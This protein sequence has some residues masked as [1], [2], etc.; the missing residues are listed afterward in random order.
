MA[1]TESLG[2]PDKVTVSGVWLRKTGGCVIVA[3]EIEGKWIDVIT[4]RA[5]S[6][7]SHIVE[8]GGI[9]EG[10]RILNRQETP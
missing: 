5:D 7:F 6:A 10:V 8:P 1:I 9:L 2:K 3:V 4:E